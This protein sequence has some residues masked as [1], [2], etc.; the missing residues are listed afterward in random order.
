MPKNNSSSKAKSSG[1]TG[2]RLKSKLLGTFYGHPLKDM[3]LVAITGSTGRTEVA[4]FV[5]EILKAAGQP[6]AILASEDEIKIGALHKFLSEA[7]KAGANYVVVT[8]PAKSL[9]DDVFY[10]LP[11]HI[12]ALTNFI[13]SS[14]S[15]LTP[16]EYLAAESTLFKM[17]P[18]YAIL[19]R[20]DENYEDFREFAGDKGTITYGSDRLCNIQVTNS[21]LYKKGVEANLAIGT[22]R[23][24]VA[25]FLT[26]EPV[27]NYMAAAAAI[28]NTLHVAPEKITEGIANYEA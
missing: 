25:S 12:A 10:G 2:N 6:V 14:L 19:N 15:D 8:T 5:H 24:T 16:K 26:G 7:W 11:V 13:P 27:V 22:T 18:E 1:N 17:K 21:R 3:K 9:R 20:D 28:A 23:F 4:H